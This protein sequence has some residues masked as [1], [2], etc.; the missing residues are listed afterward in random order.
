VRRTW[1]DWL[2]IA[3]ATLIF[4]G[5]GALARIPQMEINTAWLML[6]AVALAGVLVAGGVVLWRVTKFS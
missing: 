5:L 4:V 3:A 6:F 2:L 1:V